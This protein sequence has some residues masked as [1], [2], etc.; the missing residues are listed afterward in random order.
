VERWLDETA[1]TAP[2]AVRA[3]VPQLLSVAELSE[4]LRALLSEGVALRDLALVL[5]AIAVERRSAPE[6]TDPG[7]LAD[8]ARRALPSTLSRSVAGENGVVRIIRLAS[9]I[10][11]TVGEAVQPSSS[12]AS[13]RLA[14]G[15]ARD[16]VAAVKRALLTSADDDHALGRQ[17]PVV[18]ASQGTRRF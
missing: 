6:S 17:A 10:E 16:V 18:L 11:D 8:V 5:E 3:V 13:C 7:Q 12:R 14:P 4:V 15:A 9:M 1:D 2:A